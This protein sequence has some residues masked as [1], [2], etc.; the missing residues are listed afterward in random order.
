MVDQVALQKQYDSVH[1]MFTLY[2]RKT[3]TM[4]LC[5]CV[6]LFICTFLCLCVS[7]C[8]VVLL[9]VSLCVC[10]SASVSVCVCVPMEHNVRGCDVTCVLQRNS[11]SAAIRSD[12]TSRIRY[13]RFLRSV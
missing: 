9:H 4:G 13:L 7:V 6:Y 8:F 3:V 1:A 2:S 11:E 12:G 10:V 5:L